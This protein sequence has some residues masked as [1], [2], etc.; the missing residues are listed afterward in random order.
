MKSCPKC[1][2]QYTDEYSFCNVCGHELV[3]GDECNKVTREVNKNI[4]KNRN[5]IFAIVIV[6]LIAVIGI[7]VTLSEQKKMKDTKQA[8]EDYKHE[9]ALQEYMSTPKTSDLRINSGWT[10]KVKGNYIYINGSVTNIS[11]NKTIS[12]FEVEAKFY[13]AKGNV[14]DSD[15]TNDGD[16]LEPNE[17]RQFEIMHKYNRNI[18]EVKLSIGDVN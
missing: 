14:I 18:D 15:W 10:S 16:E 8:I 12:Y 11:S 13:D 6:A 9:K 3:V 5:Q 1:N 2:R 17:T 4:S 7:G